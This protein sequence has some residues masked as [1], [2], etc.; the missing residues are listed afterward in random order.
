MIKEYFALDNSKSE[1]SMASILAALRNRILHLKLY[2]RIDNK[3][4][5][6]VHQAVKGKGFYKVHMIAVSINSAG[7]SIV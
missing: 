4:T 7:G 3:M 6:K 1:I 2:G 5:E